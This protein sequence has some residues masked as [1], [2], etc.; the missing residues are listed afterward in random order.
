MVDEEYQKEA[1]KFGS[2]TCLVAIF[3]QSTRDFQQA[4]LDNVRDKDMLKLGRRLYQLLMK[5]EWG[6][7]DGMF[8]D[9]KGA[10]IDVGLPYVQWFESLPYCIKALRA[11]EGAN[12]EAATA[13]ELKYHIKHR[14]FPEAHKI[15]RNYLEKVD[16]KCSYCYYALTMDCKDDKMGLGLAKKV[17]AVHHSVTLPSFASF[18]YG[19]R[20]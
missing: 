10:H 14:R 6:I 3:L 20:V 5:S 11:S 2:T 17:R 12:S 4:M 19:N 13:L 7:G 18:L 8:G 1:R 15:A 9:E 16:S